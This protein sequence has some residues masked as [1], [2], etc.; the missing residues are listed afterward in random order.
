MIQLA[1]T[2]AT[3]D[4]NQD[5]EQGSRKMNSESTDRTVEKNK[6]NT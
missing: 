3:K 2:T 1:D 6:Y 4:Y 5:L